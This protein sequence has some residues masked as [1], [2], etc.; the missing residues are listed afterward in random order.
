MGLNQELEAYRSIAQDTK[1]DLQST[2][3]SRIKEFFGNMVMRPQSY[4]VSVLKYAQLRR[5][6]SPEEII[7]KF[8]E[9]IVHTRLRVEKERFYKRYEGMGDF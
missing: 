8:Q 5:S 1:I 7:K 3:R 4:L 9:K 6:H 2:S